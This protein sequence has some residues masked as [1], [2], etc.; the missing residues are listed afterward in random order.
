MVIFLGFVVSFKRV[1]FKRVSA[2]PEKAKAITECPQ[3][4]T[5]REVRSFHGLATFYRR[6]VKNFSTIM[7]P[8]T[9]CLKNEKFQ[10]TLI[11]TKA[12][13][14]VKKLMTEAPVI[15]LPGLSKVFEVTCDAS[16]LKIG[17]VLSQ[18]N[19]SVAYFSEKLI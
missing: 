5:I 3:P 17:G 13:K 2:D 18:E 9:N 14:E 7:A 4:R 11:A 15:R 12:F 1:S 19:H 16:G 6:F 10:W 8:I